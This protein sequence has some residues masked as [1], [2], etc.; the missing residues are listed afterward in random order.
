MESIT[1]TP[2]N[3][4]GRYQGNINGLILE[5]ITRNDQPSMIYPL[6]KSIDQTTRIGVSN[7]Q[8][9]IDE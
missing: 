8:Y 2:L 4:L 9:E 1:K 6:F 5:G 3:K 7:I